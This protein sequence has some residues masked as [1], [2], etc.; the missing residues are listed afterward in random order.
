LNV[1]LPAIQFSF[2]PW[3]YNDEQIVRIAHKCLEIRE[4]FCSIL[5]STAQEC[6]QYGTPMIR[7]LWFSDPYDKEAQ[8]CDREYMLGHDLLIAPVLEENVTELNIYLPQGQWKC[9]H[10]EQIYDGQQSFSYPVTI[11]DIPIFERC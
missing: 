4:R 5:L 6:V 7:P 10:T 3:L 1:L 8:L 2:P 11:E 9:I